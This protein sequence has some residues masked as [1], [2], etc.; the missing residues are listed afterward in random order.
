VV[1]TCRPDEKPRGSRC[2]S[3]SG[4]PST[5]PGSAGTIREVA[6]AQAVDPGGNIYG[7]AITV[8]GARRILGRIRSARLKL[9]P[10]VLGGIIDPL[11]SDLLCDPH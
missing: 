6:R 7:F 1:P 8:R 2:T 5:T 3:D 4:G 9:V 10:L 11:P